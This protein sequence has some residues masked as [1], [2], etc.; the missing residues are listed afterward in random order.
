[1]RNTMRK[2]SWLNKKKS[3]QELHDMKKKL[4]GL[5]LHTVCAGAACPNRA[6]CFKNRTATFMIMGDVCTRACKFCGVSKLNPQ[7]IDLD[8][9]KN[10]AI[11][12]KQLELEYVVITCV[13]RDDIIDGGAKHFCNVINAIHEYNPSVKIEILTSDFYSSIFSTGEEYKNLLKLKVEDILK[14]NIVVFGHNIETVER[15]YPLT[16]RISDYKRSL[17]VLKVV[18]EVDSKMITKSS[19]MLGLGETVEEIIA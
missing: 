2:P 18:K 6:E 14:T 16:R 13:T 11:M 15:I 3:L 8:E 1:M 10:I 17:D 9:P 4:R 7:P 19:F 5:K 12:V